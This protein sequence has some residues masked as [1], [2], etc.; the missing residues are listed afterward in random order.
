MPCSM[1]WSSQRGRRSGVVAQS[2]TRAAPTRE[3]SSRWVRGPRLH[4]PAHLGI[5]RRIATRQVGLGLLALLVAVAGIATALD[6]RQAP[7]L[8]MLVAGGGHVVLLDPDGA[9]ARAGI[10][11]GDAITAVDGGAVAA[12]GFSALR[13][14]PA[15]DVLAL[16][17]GAPGSFSLFWVPIVGPSQTEL[18]GDA[19]A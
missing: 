4:R 15:G 5:A 8:G 2:V 1:A 9:A 10:R 17:E 3:A 14:H 11:V 7:R 13:A 19:T 6:L 12:A 18:A 16:S